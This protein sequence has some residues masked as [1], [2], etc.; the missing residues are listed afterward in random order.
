MPAHAPNRAKSAH[1]TGGKRNH[2]LIFCLGI[3]QLLQQVQA[4]GNKN[5]DKL[6]FLLGAALVLGLAE[7]PWDVPVK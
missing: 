6:L 5:R 3:S 7:V 2:R 1:Y 4:K